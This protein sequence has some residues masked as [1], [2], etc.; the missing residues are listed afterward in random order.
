MPVKKKPEPWKDTNKIKPGSIPFAKLACPIGRGMKTVPPGQGSAFPLE[1]EFTSSG[2]PGKAGE[3]DPGTAIPQP[4]VDKSHPGR[5]FMEEEMREIGRLENPTQEQIRAISQKYTAIWKQRQAGEKLASAEPATVSPVPRTGPEALAYALRNLDVDKVEADAKDIIQRKL[6]SKRP[7]AV[8]RLGA[9]DGFRRANMVPG[10]LLMD[11]IP[12]IPPAFRPFAMAGET[13]VP[14]DANELYRDLIDLRDTYGR[15]EGVL[16]AEGAKDMRLQLYDAARAVYGFADPVN[17][18]TRER[19]VSGFLSKLVGTS[20]KFSLFQRKML[21][22]D[23][24]FTGR[25]VISLDP[26]LDMDQIGLPEDMAWPVYSTHVQRRLVR[27]GM[28]ATQALTAIKEKNDMARAALEQEIGVR[29]VIYSRA[30]AWHKFNVIS[31][32]PK[33]IKGS[34]IMINPLV[35]TGMN[36]DFDGDTAA[37]HVPAMDDSVEEAKN[38]LMPSKMLFSIK[39]RE[40][41]VPTPKQEF[42]LGLYNAQNRKSTAKHMF[43]S[44][45]DALAAVRSGKIRLSDEIEIG[46]PVP[47]M[48]TPPPVTPVG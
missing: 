8:K 31:G 36:A 30:P 27:G 46:P 5:F 4:D 2:Y 13:F 23:V 7:D 41:V 9:I 19:G 24:D 15:V 3:S 26:D 48:A 12:V 21:S 45:Q 42:I 44:E 6:V 20:P 22:K 10:D 1:D 32:W 11:R 35:T 14:G 25:G 18:K 43:N 37:I 28:T 17:P 47:P 34:T 38:L 16:G 29:P 39:D 33:L 40:K